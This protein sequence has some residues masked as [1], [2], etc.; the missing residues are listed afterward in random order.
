MSG[1]L[2]RIKLGDYA[3][4]DRR[5]ADFFTIILA[6]RRPHPGFAALDCHFSIDREAMLHVEARAA[7][8]ADPRSHVNDIAEFDR[9]EEI[10]ARVDQWNSD[11]AERARQFV[12]LD[13]EC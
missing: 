5:A 3:V 7:E 13:P 9:L 2:R 8:F 1:T 12:R 4:G 6:A 10:G 11:N